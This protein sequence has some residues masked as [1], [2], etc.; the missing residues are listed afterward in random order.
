MESRDISHVDRTSEGIVVTFGDGYKFLFSSTH[1]YDTRLKN[2]QL[3]EAPEE[4][5]S[6]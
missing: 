4:I 3:V 6:E 2:G 5:D 1:L